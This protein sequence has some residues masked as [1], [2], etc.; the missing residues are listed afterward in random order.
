LYIERAKYCRCH[1][2]TSRFQYATRRIDGHSPR[3]LDVACFETVTNGTPAPRRASMRRTSTWAV[4]YIAGKQ[5][6]APKP[7]SDSG[8]PHHNLRFQLYGCPRWPDSLLTSDYTPAVGTPA[9]LSGVYVSSPHQSQRRNLKVPPFQ[10]RHCR[11]SARHRRRPSPRW[12]AS[13]S[14]PAVLS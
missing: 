6:P 11:R 12:Q 2:H 9:W 14:E 5:R 7:I 3:C 8:T 4:R 13:D 10:P 1:V